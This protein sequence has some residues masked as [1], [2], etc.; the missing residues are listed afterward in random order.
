MRRAVSPIAGL[1]AWLALTVSADPFAN[2]STYA[3]PGLV[4]GAGWSGPTALLFSDDD[5]HHRDQRQLHCRP[6]AAVDRLSQRQ[7][8][9]QSTVVALHCRL[10]MLR[11][12]PTGVPECPPTSKACRCC[13][14]QSAL[15]PTKTLSSR[16]ASTCP[17]GSRRCRSPASRSRRP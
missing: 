12:L 1:F 3:L 5:H 8:A 14:R 6:G 7:S 4:A 17:T 13:R 9:T 16:W 15:G 2:F 10:P 11:L